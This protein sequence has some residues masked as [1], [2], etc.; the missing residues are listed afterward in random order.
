MNGNSVKSANADL[1]RSHRWE[2]TIAVTG[3]LGSG[4]TEFTMSLAKA[5]AAAGEHI[6]L[7]DMDIINP[8]FCLRTMTKEMADENIS[9]VMPRKEL[10]W[11]DFRCVNPEVH[12]KIFD[13]GSR[14]LLDIGGDAQGAFALK[15][16]GSEIASCGYDLLFVINPYRT[17]TRTVAEVA[18]M[19]DELEA[20]GGLKIS[21]VAANP[22]FMNDTEPSDCARGILAVKGFAEKLGLPLLFGIARENLAGEVRRLLCGSVP[23]WALRRRIL[24]PWERRAS[25]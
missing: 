21:A 14:L 7:A 22:H 3:A 12:A 4:K 13:K 18:A 1:L 17:H 19:R 23:V 10:T 25:K 6:N 16:F 9:L 20:I 11:G 15:Q 5:F 2:H 24:L 8:Y